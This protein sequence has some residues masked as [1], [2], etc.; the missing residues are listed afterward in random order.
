MARVCHCVSI[1][2]AKSQINIVK[3]KVTKYSS[4]ANLLKRILCILATSAPV[5]QVFS[6][7]VMMATLYVPTD[8]V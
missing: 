2:S 6:Y 3:I 1:M 8:L 7:L 5:K 4:L